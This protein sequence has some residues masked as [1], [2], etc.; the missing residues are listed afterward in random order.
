MTMMNT[1]IVVARA[2]AQDIETHLDAFA[3]LL[4]DAVDGGASVGFLPPL[5][6]ETALDYWLE[7]SLAV[8]KRQVCLWVAWQEGTAPIASHIIGT[9]IVGSVQLHLAPQQNAFMRAEVAKLLVHGDFRRQGIA[10]ALM[11]RLEQHAASIGRTTLVLDTR[12]NDPANILYQHLGYVEVG[13]IPAYAANADGSLLTTV[14]YY[15]GVVSQAARANHPT[16]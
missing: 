4:R 2:T 5:S 9:H 12:A 10:T 13:R 11:G 7:T 15:K 14:F 3:N 6:E 1:P 16:D 8:R